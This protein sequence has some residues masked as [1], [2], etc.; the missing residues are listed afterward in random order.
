[1]LR[2]DR[3]ERNVQGPMI[4]QSIGLVRILGLSG[5]AVM[6]THITH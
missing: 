4:M 2:Q 1:M 6:H 3:A 5:G